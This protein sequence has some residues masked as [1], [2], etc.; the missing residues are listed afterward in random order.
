[1]PVCHLLGMLW[2]AWQELVCW[3]MGREGSMQGRGVMEL[4]RRSQHGD[5]TLGPPPHTHT[6]GRARAGVRR[7]AGSLV[8]Q[9][10]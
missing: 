1:M 8:K 5:Q 3:W 9:G 4:M 2:S 10:G 7:L 6:G